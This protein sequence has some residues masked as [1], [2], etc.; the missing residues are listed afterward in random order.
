[1]RDVH[2]GRV[3]FILKSPAVVGHIISFRGRALCFDYGPCF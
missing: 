1:M 2:H 3:T